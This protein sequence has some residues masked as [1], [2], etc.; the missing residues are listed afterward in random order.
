MKTPFRYLVLALSLGLLLPQPSKGADGTVGSE[1]P[2]G[3]TGEY[4]GSITTAGSYDP[5]TGNAKRAINDLTVTGSVGAYPLNFTRVLNTR[6]VGGPFGN[7]GG[8][9]HSYQWGL[10]IAPPP[11]T[12]PPPCYVPPPDA[13]ILYPDGGIR[14]LRL[15]EDDT[16]EQVDGAD[17]MGDRL[18]HLQGNNYDLKLKDGG[19][20]QFRQVAGRPGHPPTAIVDPYGQ[21]TTLEYDT[22]NRLSIIKEPAGRFL[23]LHYTAYCY[24]SQA[25][26]PHQVCSDFIT[27]VEA[28]DGR[29]NLMEKVL[30]HYDPVIT[31]SPFSVTYWNL[32]R[33]T[34]D[35]GSAAEY[36]YYE[37]TLGLPSNLMT[38]IPG[39]V[40]T[41]RDTRYAGAMKNIKYLYSSSGACSVAPGQ[42]LSENNINGQ[43][44]S[45]L[46]YP[47]PPACQ[48]PI[49]DARYARIEQR[50]DGATRKFQ[51][52]R[53]GELNSYTDF[54]KPNLGEVHHTTTIT[55][56]EPAPA[57]PAHYLRTV[58]D[59]RMKSTSMEKEYNIGAVMAVIHP[60]GSRID[61]TY[62][63]PNNPYYVASQK[64]ENGHITYY[65]RY[66]APGFPPDPLN[67]NR[68]W[69]IRYPDGG[70]EVFTYNN[71]GQVLWHRMTSGG[72]ENF[73]YD[74]RGLKETY[75]PPVT[76]SGSG[77]TR[78]F[79][80]PSGAQTDRLRYV[81]D[82][83]WNSTWYEYN[84]R[85]QVT[86]LTH[87]DSTFTQSVYNH[88]GTLQW[89]EDELYHKTSYLYDEYKRVTE[90][91]NHLNE[92]ISN[93][94][95]PNGLN[96]LSHT[97]SSVYRVTS[98]MGKVIDYDYDGNFRRKWMTVAPATNDAATN[99]YTYDEVGNLKTV[100]DPRTKVTTYEYDDRNR[101]RS[102]RNDELNETTTTL[103][104]DAG[105][106][107]LE[108]REDG[109]FRTWDYDTM[110][111]LWKA[112]D[113]RTN[114]TA[115]PN[116]TTTYDRDHAGNALFITDT[117]G[118]VYSFLYDKLNRKE[119]ATN[120]SDSTVP[121]RTETWLYD[122][123]GNLARYTNP[124]GQYR[125]FVYDDRNRQRRSYWNLLATANTA[126]N[127]G[128]GQ[129]ITTT[130]D[131]ASRITEITT[132]GGETIVGFGYDHANRKIWEDQTVYP[133][134]ARRVKTEL[135]HDGKRMNLEIVDPPVEGGRFIISAEMS[136]SGYYSI[137]Y[138]Y[139]ER[140]QL[141]HI[142]GTGGEDW[143]FTY[144]YDASGNMMSRRADY[145][146]TSNSTKCPNGDYDALNRPRTWEQTGPNGFYKL[147]HYR[148]DRVNRED[149]TWRA[150]NDN[151]GESYE[152]EVTNQLKKVS[153]NTNINPTPPPSPTPPG[154]TPTPPNATPTPPGATPTPPDAT[155]TPPQQVAMP[156]F[157]P[158]GGNYFPNNSIWITIATTTTGAKISWTNDGSDPTPDNGTVIHA[159]SGTVFSGIRESFTLKAI[160]FKPGMVDSA[161]K[162]DGYIWDTGEAP[163]A[164]FRTVTYLH[165]PD[166]LNR[167]SMNDNGVITNYS[168]NALNQ[169][170]STAGNSF[171]YDNN[172][173]L[174]HSAGFSGVYNAANRLVLGSNGGSGEAQTTVA[175]FVYDGLGRCVKRTFNNVATVFVYDGWKPIGEFDET[176]LQAWNVYGPGADEI[177][178]RQKDGIGYTRFLLDRHGNV[179]FLL[180][181]DGALVEKYT[182]DVFGQPKITGAASD[183]ERPF[184]YYGHNFL[185]QGRE[186]IHEL[187]LYDYRNRFYDPKLG[188]FLQTDPTG[189]QTEGEKLSA[190]Q[191][192]LY[193]AG[194]APAAF[195]SSELN[196]YRYC[197]S[198]PVN[199]SD[200]T[201]L[202]IMWRKP[203]LEIFK[204]SFWRELFRRANATRQA[205]HAR[206][207]GEKNSSARHQWA[208][209]KMTKE[210]GSGVARTLGVVNELQGLERH[211][212]GIS[213]VEFRGP[214]N[215]LPDR[216]SGARP[217]AFQL[218]DLRD[219]EIGISRALIQMNPTSNHSTTSSW[220]FLL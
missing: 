112:Y 146:N 149:A 148:Y 120:P 73:T 217:W 190:Q 45:T 84:S 125:H 133:Q 74:T 178:L 65:D 48:L 150:E 154:A 23:Q 63:D 9:K 183:V 21:T 208:A 166:M 10:Y 61:Y 90:I 188:R 4:N 140:N 177:L 106:K 105:N 94:Y 29:N 35:D 114:V 81:E 137:A 104:D 204:P 200:P 135:D 3:V 51:Y 196:L 85:G 109:A 40:D 139:T 46:A 176:D 130:P 16:Y 17:V 33:V 132:N 39:K 209:E 79:Y 58:T 107:K 88:D 121:A 22:L 184:S 159:S 69:R 75:T 77:P 25:P 118:A 180:D 99:K 2:T 160:A 153:Y 12:N 199:N 151:R 198:D 50:P 18:V 210:Q 103:F 162:E 8:W 64:D 113:W 89:S 49:T 96:A 116:Q 216:L 6:G 155:P 42:L 168:P 76:A 171:T 13:K 95:A 11:M 78:Y 194:G 97:T 68:I 212:L 57:N 129:D 82:P 218:Q 86:K 220:I 110:N 192:A 128:I 101:Q 87:Q 201:G 30:Y 158:A 52:D 173:N 181:N 72:E 214:Q 59:A 54:A 186:Y 37:P 170:T 55:Y 119:S 7:G 31:P 98:D 124:A 115:Q 32:D 100:E 1:N 163:T 205:G 123:A 26:E 161:V 174:T 164:G 41:C 43:A 122:I 70:W 66:G 93:S 111:R 62:S 206:F 156:T 71:R 157:N 127:W 195:S 134:P 131:A 27:R 202:V 20:V 44:L 34:Y 144:G 138:D 182:Y 14:I 203:D 185:F 207:P 141:W 126:A 136:G 5:F 145:N 92:T 28:W 165:T 15:L 102:V 56:M 53:V 47:T 193:P 19:V 147:S 167:S 38:R 191:T 83:R 219:N 117:K 213:P 189:L 24:L 169:Y 211:D 172:F 179:A 215:T 142:R 175:G 67:T 108:T 143:T 60:N 152:Y 187:R 36:G 80:H 197:N 91:T